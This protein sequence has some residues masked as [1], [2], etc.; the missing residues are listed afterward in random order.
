ML[1]FLRALIMQL[2]LRSTGVTAVAVVPQ[3]HRAF[4]RSAACCPHGVPA[5]VQLF[6]TAGMGGGTGTGSAPVAA[7][8]A[9]KAGILTVAVVT[10]PF[11]FEGR[12]RARQVRAPSLL[13]A[14][15]HTPTTHTSQHSTRP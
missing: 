10:L 14:A 9:K 1:V 15:A 3:A 6:L 8:I 11:T 12:R 13:L 5:S 2:P 4:A 7:E